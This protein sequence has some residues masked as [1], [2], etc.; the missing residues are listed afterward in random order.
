MKEKLHSKLIYENTASADKS[1]SKVVTLKQFYSIR[2]EIHS[3]GYYLAQT[4][5]SKF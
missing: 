3:L 5:S 4:Y 1:A 2:L